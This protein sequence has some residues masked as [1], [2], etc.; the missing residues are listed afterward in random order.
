MAFKIPNFYA[1]NK[2]KAFAKG[3]EASTV[4]SPLNVSYD[5]AYDNISLEKK[6]D[7]TKEQFKEKAK[8]YN[9]DNYGTTEPTKASKDGKLNDKQNKALVKSKEVAKKNAD[10]VKAKKASESTK[11]AETTKTDEDK[12]VTPK[13]ARRARRS[14]RIKK[15]KAKKEGIQEVKDSGL[16]GKAKREAKRA[17]RD[18]VGKTKVGKFLKKTK[19]AVVGD[20]LGNKKKEKKSDTSVSDSERSKK[21]QASGNYNKD[22]SPKSAE[23]RGSALAKLTSIERRAARKQGKAKRA[24]NDADY[25]K[26]ERKS[27]DENPAPTGK[28][29][30]RLQ[31]KADRKQTK[32]DK[33]MKKA[34]ISSESLSKMSDEKRNAIY[35]KAK[36]HK[37][38]NR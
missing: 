38:K 12:K 2:Q 16:K 21:R 37:N 19:D 32:A 18:K 9:T 1:Q 4:P 6:K 17:V 27:F 7:M 13:N 33:L 3:P 23:E 31:K 22:G 5:E 8:K 30:E 36:K 29:K 20:G 35:D 15:R 14:E 24:Q 28:K 10:A 25:G 11:T 34:D 26:K